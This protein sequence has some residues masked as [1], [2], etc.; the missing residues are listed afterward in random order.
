MERTQ[1]VQSDRITRSPVFN[2]YFKEN[3]FSLSMF[4]AYSQNAIPLAHG[5][6][7]DT[8]LG[9]IIFLRISLFP[10]ARLYLFLFSSLSLII[11]LV[12]FL[13]S[14]VYFG[15]S[16]ALLAGIVNYIILTINFHRKA[17]EM[18]RSLKTILAGE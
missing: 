4:Y 13:T 10:A 9:S 17:V 5:I 6:V 11:A 15:G 3:R 14:E 1:L 16:M 7:E 8:S 18:L 12:F 2:G